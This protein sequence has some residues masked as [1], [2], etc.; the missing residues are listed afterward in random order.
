MALAGT[1]IPFS[2]HTRLLPGPSSG[3]KG[4][5]GILDPDW[6]QTMIVLAPLLLL[7]ITV[8]EY[9]HARV[10]LAFGDPTAKLMGRVTFNPLAHLDPMG[11]LVLLVT[12][13]YGWAKPVPVNPLNLDPRRL[14][15]IMVSLAGPLSNLGLAIVCGLLFRVLLLLGEH[16]VVP[17]EGLWETVLQMLLLTVGANVGLCV[18]NLLPLF[19]LDGHHIAR[20]LL[21]LPQQTGFM[22]WQMRFGHVALLGLVFVPRL[23]SNVTGGPVP[24]P[25]SLLRSSVMSLAMWLLGL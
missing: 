1:G 5:M 19:P 12:G 24:N 8:H 18:F 2:R 17:M 20:E 11:T 14:G 7:S 15:D 3:Y 22:N 10:A 16:G 25:L 21:P 6:L 9:A 4:R 13:M 23:L